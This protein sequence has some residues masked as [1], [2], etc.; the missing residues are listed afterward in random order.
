[1]DPVDD[2]AWQDVVDGVPLLG[3]LT[4][5]ERARTR[6]LAADFLA[7]KSIE[8]AG[9]LVVTPGMA[10]SIAAQASIP[11]IGLD[12]DWYRG[13]LS[14]VVYP[15][16]FVAPHEYIDEAGVVHEGS[17]ALAGESWDRGPIVLS[18]ETVQH[19]A[20]GAEWG[21]VVIHE[22]AHKL[23]L[24][25][26][27]ANGKPPLGG[28]AERERWARVMSEAFERVRDEARFLD[29]DD[30]LAQASEDPG[31][32]FAVVSEWFHVEP[33]PLREELPEVYAELAAFYRRDPLS[34]HV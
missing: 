11:L 3:R 10:L 2:D 22:C 19:T 33:R 15:A 31:E 34:R 26:G 4:L 7:R 12:L 8:G 24:L 29:P 16:D 30:A 13:W 28:S 5:P 23:D 20:S 14:V 27:A 9:A 21:N 18:W 1:V 32:F 17:R 6:S 25:D